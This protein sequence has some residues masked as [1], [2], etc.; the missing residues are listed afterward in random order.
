MTQQSARAIPG[1]IV[2]PDT[3]TQCLELY[4]RENLISL[5]AWGRNLGFTHPV[6]VTREAV[7]LMGDA[8]AEYTDGGFVQNFTER[9]EDIRETSKLRPATSVFIVGQWVD[10]GP[11]NELLVRQNFEST[12]P[13]TLISV[14]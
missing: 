9:L 12:E 14:W 5:G 3:E 1:E 7:E 4:G 6:L 8:K 11:A 2:M 13:F 10:G